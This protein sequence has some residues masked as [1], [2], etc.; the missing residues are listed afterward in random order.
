MILPGALSPDPVANSLTGAAV[1]GTATLL[2]T[3]AA[4]GWRSYV[5]PYRR[6]R[7]LVHAETA[8]REAPALASA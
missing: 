3:A 6:V 2:A 1:G 4:Y 8:G 7:R 5:V